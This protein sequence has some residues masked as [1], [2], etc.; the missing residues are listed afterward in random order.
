M[1]KT[2]RYIAKRYITK[3]SRVLV[4]GVVLSATT[5]S[6]VPDTTEYAYRYENGFHIWEPIAQKADR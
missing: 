5:V 3:T 2:P 1:N 4:E 6:L